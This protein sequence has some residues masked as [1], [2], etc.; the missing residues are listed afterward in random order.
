MNRLSVHLRLL[1][2]PADPGPV[3]GPW[4][5]AASSRLCSFY[6]PVPDL[7]WRRE[8]LASVLSS[9]LGRRT[10]RLTERCVGTATGCITSGLLGSFPAAPE[11]TLFDRPP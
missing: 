11:S 5:E 2:D 6:R 8:R 3:E 7:L 4:H 1:R 10:I 9:S